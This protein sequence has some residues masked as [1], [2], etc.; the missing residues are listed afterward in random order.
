MAPIIIETPRGRV[1]HNENMEAVLEWNT[2]FKPKWQKRYS[3]AQ[4]F[5]DS[6]VLRLC[7]PYVPL[8]T[9]MLIK[10]GILGTEIGSGLVRWIAPYARYQYYLDRKTKSQTGPLRGSLWFHRMKAAHGRKIVK[11]AKKIAG[12]SKVWM[13]TK[14]YGTR[15]TNGS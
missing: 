1:F 5:V 9:G 10:S 11:T 15:P 14:L 2:N 4:K 6:E 8:L 3:N 7:E 12:G 13:P